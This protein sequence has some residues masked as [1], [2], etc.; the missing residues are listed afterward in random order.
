[1]WDSCQYRTFGERVCARWVVDRNWGLCT[2][3]YEAF[4]TS[5]GAAVAFFIHHF[6]PDGYNPPGF[7]YQKGARGY[8][9][10]MAWPGRT[11]RNR[12]GFVELRNR[13]LARVAELA[14]ALPSNGSAPVA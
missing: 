12:D 5:P 7:I 3:H 8:D 11:T 6:M 13:Y 10:Y 9:G 2:V 1:M 14:D 4:K